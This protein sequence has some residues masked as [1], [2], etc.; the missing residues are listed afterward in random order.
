MLKIVNC[1]VTELT[2]RL[3]GLFCANKL[4]T[5]FALVKRGVE[6]DPATFA[7]AS[8]D[9]L[10]TQDKFI[11][12]IQFF[13][14]ENNDQEADYATSVTKERRLTMPGTKGY[15]FTFDKGSCFQNELAKLDG[16]EQYAFIPIFDDGSALFA[17]KK[18]GKLTGFDANLFVGV[19]Q[20]RTTADLAGSTL[21]V[22]ITPNAM[23]YWQKSSAVYESDEFSF[24]ELNPVAGVRIVPQ[25]VAVG[26][27]T[28][29]NVTN[30]CSDAVV[31]GLTD[32]ENWMLERNGVLEAITA[33]SE[34]AGKYTLTHA[35]LVASQKVRFLL[36]K[37]GY[38]VYVLDTNYY[39]GESDVKTVA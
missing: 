29:V 34:V 13:N 23:T 27:S 6:I 36:Y 2:P 37:A 32:D 18:N 30:L 1:S 4:M 33:V 19:M 16:S 24:G 39:A 35:A 3:G 15:T 7:K 26:T 20:L 11:G 25:A 14:V 12:A 5:K 38:L 9:T 17:V 31:T 21:M 22:D 8:L 28:V 10:I